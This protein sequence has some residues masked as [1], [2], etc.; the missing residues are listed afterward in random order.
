MQQ[1]NNKVSF[2]FHSTKDLQIMTVNHATWWTE[3]CK[4]IISWKQRETQWQRKVSWALWSNTEQYKAVLRHCKRIYIVI[5]FSQD[6]YIFSS[7]GCL[8]NTSQYRVWFILPAR[9]S[10]HH[11]SQYR[12]QHMQIPRD[13]SIMF[14]KFCK[15]HAEAKSNTPTCTG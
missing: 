11:T 8:G 14:V 9:L 1:N 10:S 13:R 2:V 7:P 12:T 5:F 3:F 15:V 4:Y 6:G